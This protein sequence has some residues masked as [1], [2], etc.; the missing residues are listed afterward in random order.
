MQK[1][2]CILLCMSDEHGQPEIS[3]P[4][5]FVSFFSVAVSRGLLYIYS[6]ETV[7]IC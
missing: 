3:M 6:N 2:V 5:V 4:V 7:Q 1:H